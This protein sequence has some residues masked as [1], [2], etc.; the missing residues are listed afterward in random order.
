M[1][2]IA[3]FDGT[4]AGRATDRRLRDVLKKGL[5][6]YETVVIN[7]PADPARI[8]ADLAAGVDSVLFAASIPANGYN[9][10]LSEFMAGLAGGDIDLSGLI[11]GVVIDGESEFFTKKLGRTLVFLANRAG[12]SFPGK[13]LVEATGHLYNFNT[14]ARAAGADNITAYTCAVSALADRLGRFSPA[15]DPILKSKTELQLRLNP[16]SEPGQKPDIVTI[17]ASSRETSNSLLLWSLIAEKLEGK[18]NIQEIPIRNGTVVDCRG[19]SF[20]TCRHFGESGDCFYGGIM[21]EKVYPA[22]MSCDQLVLICPNYN[23]SV[24]ANITAFFNR[25]TALFYNND[26]SGKQI[27]A[28]IVSGYSG[29]DIVAEQI[30]GAMNLNKGFALP[31]RFAMIETAN[32]PR[33]ILEV[34]NIRERAAAF[35]GEMLKQ[36]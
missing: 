24:S 36:R 1:I 30:I 4:S 13:P 8:H 22:I 31:A 16:Q 17:H 29:G 35:A 5:E 23:D 14:S 21:V 2:G 15:S 11:G 34:E 9:R 12:M 20:E 18:A 3:I 33:S 7:D 25:L 10:A 27:R 6:N 32:D 19:C 28:L 26:F